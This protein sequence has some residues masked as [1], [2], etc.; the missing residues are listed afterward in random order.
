ME[1]NLRTLHD[2]DK[3]GA[4]ITIGCLDLF[5]VHRL[6]ADGGHDLVREG[7]GEHIYSGG[8]NQSTKGINT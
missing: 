3:A 5:G 6:N 2:G 8:C 4:E 1:E 7:V